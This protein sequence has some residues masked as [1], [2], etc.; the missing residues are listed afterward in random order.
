MEPGSEKE[1][2]QDDMLGRQDDAEFLSDYLIAKCKTEDDTNSSYVLNIDAD[3]GFGKTYF[4][5]Q[6]EQ[7]TLKWTQ[8]QDRF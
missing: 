2:W 1:L 6:L 8:C 7:E 3:W 5:K 4:M